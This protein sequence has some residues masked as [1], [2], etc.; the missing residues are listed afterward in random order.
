MEPSKPVER[1]AKSLNVQSPWGT[2]TVQSVDTLK[3]DPP[4][5]PIGVLRPRTV[6]RFIG[7][8]AGRY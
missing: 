3:Q 8:P 1:Y 2:T 7:L 6:R 5:H 4:G